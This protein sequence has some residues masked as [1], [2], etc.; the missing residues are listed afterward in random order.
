MALPIKPHQDTSNGLKVHIFS[1]AQTETVPPSHEM[2]QFTFKL[3]SQTFPRR[4][5]KLQL[6]LHSLLQTLN[7][8]LN[9]HMRHFPQMLQRENELSSPL[10]RI[11]GNF[12]YWMLLYLLF[13]W[14]TKKLSFKPKHPTDFP[15]DRPELLW[16]H[17]SLGAA[18]M[19]SVMKVL[20][21]ENAVRQN[22]SRDE[23]K[24]DVTH[25]PESQNSN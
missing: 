12:L 23:N 19:K 9:C 11:D 20:E 7:L 5:R 18:F 1:G 2:T 25:E 16:W 17:S 8:S 24:R 6:K 21:E 13:L 4:S 3:E 15:L 22:I 14:A 10:K